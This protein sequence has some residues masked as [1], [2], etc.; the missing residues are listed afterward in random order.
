MHTELGFSS[1]TPSKS[2]IASFS[3][4]KSG[5]NS[6]TTKKRIINCLILTAVNNKLLLPCL[7]IKARAAVSDVQISSGSTS[8]PNLL[9]FSN[10][11][12]LDSLV[13]FVQKR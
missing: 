4:R 8:N 2:S 12:F 9:N 13:V 7:S 1:L 10:R 11:Q 5:R 6:K 3:I